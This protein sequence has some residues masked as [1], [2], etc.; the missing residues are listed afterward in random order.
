[1]SSQE[2]GGW[3][4][5]ECSQPEDGVLKINYVCHHCGKL[6]CSRHRI[7]VPDGAFSGAVVSLG[8]TAVHCPDC[9]EAYHRIAL[10]WTARR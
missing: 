1:M 8:R 2:S 3:E 4:C 10:P 7:E 5:G 9:L 6:L